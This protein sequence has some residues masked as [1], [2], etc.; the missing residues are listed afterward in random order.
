MSSKKTIKK[1]DDALQIILFCIDCNPKTN[2]SKA[3]KHL[4]IN[5]NFI[6]SLFK[7]NIIKNNGNNRVSNYVVLHKYTPKMTMSVLSIANKLS[8]NKKTTVFE[9]IQPIE[10]A[11]P[12]LTF[13][14]RFCKIFKF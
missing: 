2:L 1:Y 14:Q 4:K 8:Q 11:Q 13:F 10:V 9:Q 5:R 12:K 3:T 6:T 7:L